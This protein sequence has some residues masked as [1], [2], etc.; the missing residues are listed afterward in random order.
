M[1]LSQPVDSRV[2]SAFRHSLIPTL[3]EV[4]FA[5][6]AAR[7]V[8]IYLQ[9]ASSSTPAAKAESPLSCTRFLS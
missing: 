8:V 7:F 1:I 4:S 2:I 3:G 9:S 6:T 5:E